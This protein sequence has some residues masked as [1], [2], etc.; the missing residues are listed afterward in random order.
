MTV[1]ASGKKPDAS[2]VSVHKE[3]FSYERLVATSV[4]EAKM[5][6]QKR[7]EGSVSGN[8]GN[9]GTGMKSYMRKKS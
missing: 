6:V 9:G 4:M 7:R 2:T 5:G 3:V 8:E 1:D